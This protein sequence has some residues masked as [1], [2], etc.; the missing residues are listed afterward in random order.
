MDRARRHVDHLHRARA[1]IGPNAEYVGDKNN[2]RDINEVEA[3]GPVLH[4]PWASRYASK[5]TH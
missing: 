1:A 3:A 5:F 2:Y 4:W